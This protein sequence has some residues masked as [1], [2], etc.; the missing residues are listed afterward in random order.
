MRAL[1]T[2]LFVSTLALGCVTICASCGEPSDAPVDAA[3]AG[4]GATHDAEDGQGDATDDA[5]TAP[6]DGL[7]VVELGEVSTGG[8][9]YG[10]WVPLQLPVGVTTVTLVL[11]SADDVTLQLAGWD[12]PGAVDIAPKAWLQTAG[13]A[14]VC[15]AP[16]ANRLLAQPGVAAFLAPNTPLVELRPGAHAIRPYAF[17]SEKGNESGMATKV[18]ITAYLGWPTPARRRL[19]L[20]VALT[21]AGG[22]DR[23]TAPKS[24]ELQQ[25]LATASALLG[26]AGI[27]LGPI[28]YHDVDPTLR[29]VT[30]RQGPKSDLAQLLASGADFEPG[31]N[32][33]LVDQIWLGGGGIPGLDLMLGL[34]GG[35]PGDPFGHDHRR[36]GVAIAWGLGTDQEGLLGTVIA[37]ELGH[38]LGLFHTT[39]APGSDGALLPDNLPDTAAPAP[40]NLMHWSVTTSCKDLSHEQRQV[41]RRSAA[42]RL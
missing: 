14:A 13:T 17:R 23:T 3:E 15:L 1:L 26:V 39:E 30:S 8:D 31:L 42:L 10:P 25:A 7:A 6:A 9:G 32:L 21:G 4:D 24:P 40:Q 33:F 36:A 2:S 27:E 5:V 19:A 28:R 18:R 34:A 16:C 20:N 12:Q 38:Y 22:L 41:L 35:I 29:F 11:R 37:H